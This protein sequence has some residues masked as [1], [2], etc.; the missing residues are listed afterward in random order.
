MSNMA[1]DLHLPDLAIL[2]FRGIDSLR[3]PR[4]GRVT[5]VVG[6]NG[7]G[8]TTLIEAIRAYASRG[9]TD[10]LVA[11]LAERE[12]FH[13]VHLDHSTSTINWSPLFYERDPEQVGEFSIGPIAA[14]QRLYIE[15]DTLWLGD[16]RR[17]VRAN[18]SWQGSGPAAISLRIGLGHSKLTVSNNRPFNS[19][20]LH[21]PPTKAKHQLSQ[22]VTSDA[23]STAV[24]C[25]N[26]GPREVDS[27]MIASLWPSVALTDGEDCTVEALRL[28]YGSKVERIAV[29]SIDDREG[30][31]PR[32]HIVVKIKGVS[33]PVSIQSLGGGAH[34]MFGV[35]LCLAASR[36]GFLTIDEAGSGIH[37]TLQYPFWKMIVETAE[38]NNVQV[39]ATTHAW[40]SVCGF[41]EAISSSGNSQGILLRLERHKGNLRAVEYSANHLSVAAREGIE[42]R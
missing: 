12:E 38:Q 15:A 25:L 39:I 19:P 10:T 21:R 3:I 7:V 2:A 20:L 13:S 32:N 14:D 35:G 5:L 30:S 11:I 23:E 42:V 24:E 17:T 16:T 22:S 41:A 18:P 34:R 4:L 28:V 1:I 36:N 31:K 27:N 33:T 6:E 8:K 37:H 40:D 9:S 26:L 29:I